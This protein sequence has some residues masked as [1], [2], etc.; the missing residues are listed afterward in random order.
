MNADRFGSS[1]R[2]GPIDVIGWPHILIQRKLLDASDF[3]RAARDRGVSLHSEDLE[4]LH[5]ARILIPIY[6]VRRPQWDIN[7]RVAS[8]RWSELQGE[9]VWTVPKDGPDLE[10]DHEHGLVR[11]GISVRF[12]PYAS[13]R[14]QTEMGVIRRREHVYSHYQLLQLPLVSRA[15]PL[16]RIRPDKLTKWQRIDFKYLR[17]GALNNRD[18]VP[19][20]T[21]LEPRYVPGILGHRKSSLSEPDG[22]HER[23]IAAFDAPGVLAALGWA[24]EALYETATSL[25]YDAASHDP[26]DDWLALVRQVHPDRWDRLKGDARLAV[27][28]RVAAE[29]IFRFLEHLQQRSTTRRFGRK[30]A[31][32]GQLHRAPPRSAGFRE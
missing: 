22:G 24:P 4:R 27:D 14:V 29:M 25:V 31:W 26:L 17:S 1:S 20:L 30:G 16:L 10:A 18:L 19:L 9:R 11:D 8:R 3:E 6:T 21:A 15:I 13:D 2:A 23:Y 12:R 5:R 7:R 32:P 28:L